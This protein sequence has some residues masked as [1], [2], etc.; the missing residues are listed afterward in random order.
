MR[1]VV[2]QTIEQQE[3]MEVVGEVL[4]PIDLLGAVREMRADAV[5]LTIR[6]P[7]ELGLFR[8][9]LAECPNLTVLSPESSGKKAFVGKFCSPWREIVDPSEADIEGALR[10]CVQVPC[11]TEGVANGQRS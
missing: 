3:D 7:R 4:D 10:H 5:I 11:S 9:L 1:E 8:P 6:G 2:W